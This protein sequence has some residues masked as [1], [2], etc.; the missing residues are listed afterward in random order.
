MVKIEKSQ[1]GAYQDQEKVVQDVGVLK[2][3]LEYVSW[4]TGAKPLFGDNSFKAGAG[5]VGVCQLT[6]WKPLFGDNSF[7]A[8]ARG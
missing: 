2:E 8:H 1:K 5:V 6:Y 7:K 4:H 3:L